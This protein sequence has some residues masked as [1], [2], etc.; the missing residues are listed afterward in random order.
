M[1]KNQPWYADI[2]VWILFF[3]VIRLVGITDPPLETLHNWRQTTGTMVARNFVEIDPSF[4]LPRIDF[5]GEKTGITGMEFPFMNYCIA[6]ISWVFGYQHWYGRLLNLIVSS[7]GVWYFYLLIRQFFTPKIA[8][9]AA[10]ILTCSAW[11]AYSRKIM[12][13]TFSMSFAIVGFY[14][15]ACYFT[16]NLFSTS[17]FKFLF[18]YV[19]FSAIGILSKLPVIYIDVLFLPFLFDSKIALKTKIMFVVASGIVLFP[20]VF[21]YFYWVPFLVEKYEFWHFFMG[22]PMAQGWLEIQQ[23]WNDALNK[24]YDV[25]LKFIGFGVFCIGLFFSIKQKNKQLIWI[26][27]L[28]FLA[29]LVIILKAGFT[30]THHGYYIVPFVPVMALIAAFGLNSIPNARVVF[31][32]LL[33]ILIENIANQQ[34]DFRIKPENKALLQLE[35]ILDRFTDKKALI[36]INSGEVPTPMYFSHR[37]GWIG[38]NEQ[39]QSE[40]SVNELHQKGLQYI[41]ILKRTFGTELVLPYQKIYNSRDFRIYQLK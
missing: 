17:S 25:A 13:D 40:N 39:L 28:S 8:L 6:G 16:K 23:H 36:F 30:F 4:W 38:T 2:R 31:V 7:I 1:F 24:F 41:V 22:K 21:W 11:F 14:Y 9:H 29:F 3:F 15:G 33:A 37:K 34:H 19:L 20:V 5:A 10:L 26:F 12:P 18:L 27:A 32:L 35:P